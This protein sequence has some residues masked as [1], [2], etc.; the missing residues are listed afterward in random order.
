V[1]TRILAL[2]GRGGAVPYADYDQWDEGRRLAAEVERT[3]AR[4]LAAAKPGGPTGRPRPDAPSGRPRKLGYLDQREWDEMEARILEAEEGLGVCRRA[5]A[6]PQVAADHRALAVRIEAVTA[7]QAEVD[8]LYARW[9][10]LEAK[11][12]G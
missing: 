9:A 3:T 8:R 11:A 6:D 7:A 4:P 10:E 5:A 12:R 2:D 1:S